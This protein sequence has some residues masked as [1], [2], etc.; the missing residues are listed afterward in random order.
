L[1]LKGPEPLYTR[2]ARD[3]ILD[4]MDKGQQY[5][6]FRLETNDISLIHASN[7]VITE[8]KN[9]AK[10]ID[11]SESFLLFFPYF[12]VLW[13]NDHWSAISLIKLYLS[14]TYSS[15]DHGRLWLPCYQCLL[16]NFEMVL[17]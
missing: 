13:Q 4:V 17:F 7:S 1:L 9:F 3:R 10:S 2:Q 8:I 15:H 12:L 5:R 16:I 11:V 6:F 14:K